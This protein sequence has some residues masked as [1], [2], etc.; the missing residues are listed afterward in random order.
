MLWL[1]IS[2]PHPTT[3]VFF[4]EGGRFFPPKDFAP[5]WERRYVKWLRVTILYLCTI[6]FP[7]SPKKVYTRTG[8]L[9]TVSYLKSI[10]P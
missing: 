1:T 4:W 8:T 7:W 5:H 6:S 10:H 3:N 2:L 9:H